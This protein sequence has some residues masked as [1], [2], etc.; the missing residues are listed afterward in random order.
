MATTTHPGAMS[1]EVPGADEGGIIM[2]KELFESLKGKS[3]EE[4]AEMFRNNKSEF[5]APEDLEKVN[6]GVESGL[7]NPNSDD[8]FNGNWLSSFGFVC[9]GEVLC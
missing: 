5:L 7:E 9:R 8:V 2:N 1:A 3:R 4:R 6:G